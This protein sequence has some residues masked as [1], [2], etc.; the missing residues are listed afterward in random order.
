MKWLQGIGAA[1]LMGLYQM[2]QGQP[3]DGIWWKMAILAAL[4]RAA[5]WAVSKLP[6][7]A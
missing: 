2:L 1:A 5:G 3:T 6:A 7:G 4:V